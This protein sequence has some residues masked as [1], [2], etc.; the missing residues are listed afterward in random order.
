MPER[1]GDVRHEYKIEAA[2]PPPAYEQNRRH[3]NKDDMLE[4]LQEVAAK[5]ELA[6]GAIVKLRKLESFDIVV[7]ADDSSSMLQPAHDIP[8]EQ[9]FLSVPSRW[10]ELK[11]RVMQIVEIATCLDQDGIDIYFLNREAHYNVGQ[12][13]DARRLFDQSPNGYTPLTKAYKRVLNEK[14]NDPEKNVLII[15]AT[16]G[17]PNKKVNGTWQKDATGFYNLLKNRP[18]PSRCPTAIM[19]CTDSEHEIGWL[20]RM[21]DTIPCIDVVDDYNAEKNEVI[22]CQGRS[23][24]FS[25]GDFVVK[26]LL[27]PID[28]VYDNLDEKKLNRRQKAEYMGLSLSDFSEQQCCVVC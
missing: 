23:F 26:T 8:P 13:E 2:P 14:L 15:V 27:G 25:H 10:E 4:R 3:K 20:N 24:P 5:Y 6:G 7:I 9:P 19:A 17:E 22:S 11:S 12:P 18:E 28:P 21:D 1:Y 16:D